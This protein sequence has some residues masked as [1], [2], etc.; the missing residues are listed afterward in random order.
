ML[1]IKLIWF[2]FTLAY[3]TREEEGIYSFKLLLP[4]SVALRKRR[5]GQHPVWERGLEAE[6]FCPPLSAAGSRS[7]T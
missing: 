4:V 1:D 6:N 5:E 2:G 7:N 3:P